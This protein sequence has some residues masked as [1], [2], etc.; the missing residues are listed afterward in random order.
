MIPKIK[1]LAVKGN[2]L[3]DDPDEEDE[4]ADLAVIDARDDDNTDGVD[5]RERIE[6]RMIC[7]PRG[8]ITVTIP[9]PPPLPR[10]PPALDREKDKS[11]KE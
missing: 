4:A 3:G 8:R 9:L 2:L 1:L 7:C 5:E 11:S 6:G 10:P